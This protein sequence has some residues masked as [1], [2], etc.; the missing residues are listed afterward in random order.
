MFDFA[1]GISGHVSGFVPCFPFPSRP[2]CVSLAVRPPQEAPCGIG[3]V[4]PYGSRQE[5]PDQS[6]QFRQG[7]D[8]LQPSST[9]AVAFSGGNWIFVKFCCWHGVSFGRSIDVCRF[10]P[11]SIHVP[12]LASRASSYGRNQASKLC[13]MAGH[14]VSSTLGFRGEC[15]QQHQWDCQIVIQGAS[16]ND[17]YCTLKQRREWW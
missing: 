16:G 12:W 3:L 5:Q 15:N 17:K 13:S 1:P 14:L 9:D 4:R 11:L 10:R 7:R 6:L 2:K 8:S